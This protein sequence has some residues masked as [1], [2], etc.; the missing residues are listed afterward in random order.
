[1]ELV[2]LLESIVVE[3]V[4]AYIICRWMPFADG[5]GLR[6]RIAQRSTKRASAGRRL[7]PEHE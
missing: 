4:S 3:I 7:A 5:G 6:P 2:C 1:M